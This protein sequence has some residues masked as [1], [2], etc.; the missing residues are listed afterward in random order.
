LS[1]ELDVDDDLGHALLFAAV[2]LIAA[3]LQLPP[4]IEEITL[5]DVIGSGLGKP[6]PA[7][8]RVVL[9]SS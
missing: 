8:D 6:I 9:R 3:P 5:L 4:E 1:K 7:D 2:V